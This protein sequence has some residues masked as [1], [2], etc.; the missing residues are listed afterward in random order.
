[1]EEMQILKLTLLNEKK[2]G[3]RDICERARSKQYLTFF[4]LHIF[5]QVENELSEMDGALN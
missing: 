2:E 5:T 1:M 3:H 4:S